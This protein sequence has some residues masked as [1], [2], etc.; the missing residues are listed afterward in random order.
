MLKRLYLFLRAPFSAV[1]KHVPRERASQ[2]KPEEKIKIAS[3]APKL[4]PLEKVARRLRSGNAEGVLSVLRRH[5]LGEAK[6]M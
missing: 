5:E 4:T 1:A 2:K 6:S 3:K